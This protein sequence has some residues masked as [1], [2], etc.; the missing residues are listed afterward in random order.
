MKTKLDTLHIAIVLRALWDR[1]LLSLLKETRVVE[2]RI[3][4]IKFVNVLVLHDNTHF[5]KCINRMVQRLERRLKDLMIL[6]TQFQMSLW[7]TS[8][9]LRMIP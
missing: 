1:L 7:N 6:T 4:C 8:T 3:W 9:V 2:M 5:L